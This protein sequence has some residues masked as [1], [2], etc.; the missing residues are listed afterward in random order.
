MRTNKCLTTLGIALISTVVLG[1]AACFETSAMPGPAAVSGTDLSSDSGSSSSPDLA[2]SSH[3]DLGAGSSAKLGAVAPSTASAGCGGAAFTPGLYTNL[4]IAVPGFTERTYVLYVPPTYS[5]TTPMPL[6]FGFHGSTWQ[7]ATFRPSIDVEGQ[8]AGGAIFVYPDG[9]NVSG[10]DPTY[11]ATLTSGTGWDLH[12][13]ASRD[14]AFFDALH[15]QLLDEL[16]VNPQRV[17]AYGRSHGSFFTTL[18]ACVRGDKLR[19]A[20]GMSGGTPWEIRHRI[21]GCGGTP[22]TTTLYPAPSCRGSLPM[23]YSHNNDD[24]TVYPE[25]GMSARDFR[26]AKNGCTAA[27]EAVPP[28]PSP[29]CVRS[30]SCTDDKKVTWCLNPTGGHS[31]QSFNDQAIW[32]FFAAL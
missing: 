29:P 11:T 6:V 23:W 2:S 16:C 13:T 10:L 25:N 1:A 30:T 32:N 19:G 3:P 8:S 24:C 31:P 17:F 18:L 26:L 9:L 28:A 4:R 7:G 20:A 21:G 15:A 27:T 22:A 5:Q 14:V 12:P